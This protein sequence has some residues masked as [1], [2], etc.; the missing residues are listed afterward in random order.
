M[1]R[2]DRGI[3]L[4]KIETIKWKDVGPGRYWM[5]DAEGE[6]QE[7]SS[8]TVVSNDGTTYVQFDDCDI[9][10]E[11]VIVNIDDLVDTVVFVPIVA[12]RFSELQL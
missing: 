4:S 2:T 1:G 7:P 11:V 5:Y 8:C 6:D 3:A 12:P 10:G 9:E